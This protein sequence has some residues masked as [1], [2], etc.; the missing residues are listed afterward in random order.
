MKRQVISTICGCTALALGLSAQTLQRQAN[1]VGGGNQDR[2][3]CTVEVYVDD[4]ARLEIRGTTATIRNVSGQPAQIR[5][6]ECSSVMPANPGD[7]RFRGIDGRGSQTLI[8]DPRN[9]GVAVVQ[10]EDREGGSE[11]YTFDLEWD[12][13]G[14]YN[15]ANTQYDRNPGPVAG[16]PNYRGND[17]DRYRTD[18]S[19]YRP[20]YRE[21]A[22]YRRYNHGFATEEAV[23]V[24]QQAVHEQASRKGRATDIHFLRTTIDNNPGRQ[25]W[26]IGS[27]DLHRGPRLE[28]YNFSCSV[29]FDNGT[30]RSAQLD[31]RPV[32]V[33]RR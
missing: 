14:S 27:L 22:Y 30:V 21:G 15:G 17:A 19:Q 1:I 26:V 33:D 25:D 31:A 16:N 7:F 9:G 24:C 4:V 5:R 12:A 28:T 13:R 20:G 11:G 29:D 8:S 3:K 2:G 10:I 6:F 32:A 18:D 23:R